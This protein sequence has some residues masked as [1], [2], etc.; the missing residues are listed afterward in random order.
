MKQYGYLQG[1][2]QISTTVNGE[3]SWKNGDYAIWSI[4]SN[5]ATWIIGSLNRIGGGSA[6]IFAEYASRGLT[7]SYNEWKFWNGSS[8]LRPSNPEDIRITCNGKYFSIILSNNIYQVH[9]IKSYKIGEIWNKFNHSVL[10]Q[11]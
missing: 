5:S 7:I 11:I 6:F 8:F 4:M 3:P 2:Y 10:E 1:D 9:K